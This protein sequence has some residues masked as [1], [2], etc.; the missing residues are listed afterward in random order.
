[1]FRWTNLFSHDLSRS[2]EGNSTPFEFSD[3]GAD[4]Q[5]HPARQLLKN[6]PTTNAQQIAPAFRLSIS[7]RPDASTH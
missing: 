2:P 7:E 4:R 5:Q 3:R 1:M 6:S